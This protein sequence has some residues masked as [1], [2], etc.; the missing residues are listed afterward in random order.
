MAQSGDPAAI[1]QGFLKSR[2]PARSTG[3]RIPFGGVEVIGMAELQ[4]SLGLID[5]T[6][7]R[8]FN[9]EMRN[10]GRRVVTQVRAKMPVDSGAARNS[11]KTGVRNGSAYVQGGKLTV[12]YYAWLEYGGKLQPTGKRHNL[13]VRTRKPE[14]RY[15]YPTVEEMRPEI[16][17]SAKAAFEQTKRELG[18]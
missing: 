7:K 9:K 11:I 1:L 5:K 10:I 14:G 13:I 12:P 6:L 15:L 18:L 8:E 16:L 3:R 17:E 2:T 4:K